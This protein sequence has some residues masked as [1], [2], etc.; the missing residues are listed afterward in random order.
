MSLKEKAKADRLEHSRTRY[1]DIWDIAPLF[2]AKRNQVLQIAPFRNIAFREDHVLLCFH[3]LCSRFCQLQVCNEDFGAVR[4]GELGEGE[5]DAWTMALTL[6]LAFGK[7]LSILTRSPASDHDYFTL[8][9]EV[10]EHLV[11]NLEF[12]TDW[13]SNDCAM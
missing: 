6:A 5:I 9:W 2:D 7:E 1:V 11:G 4:V 3:K 12:L 13:V 10:T 8:D